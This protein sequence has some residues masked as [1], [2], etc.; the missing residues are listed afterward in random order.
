M[1]TNFVGI[2]K[3]QMFYQLWKFRL[4]SL[5]IYHFIFENNLYGM[6]TRRSLRDVPQRIVFSVT[7]YTL[8]HF[9]LSTQKSNTN[10]NNLFFKNIKFDEL[11]IEI[12]NFLQERNV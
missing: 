7:L 1:L 12:G 4:D 6:I 8:I 9:W 5:L 3:Q 2:I 11:L 10:L